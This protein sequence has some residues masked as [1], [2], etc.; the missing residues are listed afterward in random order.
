MDCI[1]ICEQC[2]ISL[3]ELE[4]LA[5]LY[6][7]ERLCM[8]IRSSISCIQP[9]RALPAFWLQLAGAECTPPGTRV[10]LEDVK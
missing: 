6:I 10:Q 9:C 4:I 5:F 2:G 8:K 3:D 7:L 1:R